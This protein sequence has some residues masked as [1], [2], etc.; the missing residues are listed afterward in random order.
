MLHFKYIKIQTNILN[1]NNSQFYSIFGQINVALMSIRDIF[2]NIKNLNSSKKQLYDLQSVFYRNKLL[3]RPMTSF[4]KSK[5]N[6]LLNI[7]LP[8]LSGRRKK[9]KE[10]W[11]IYIVRFIPK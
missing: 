8:S 7:L 9:V 2:Q 3:K 10:I 5:N 4:V 6:T 11:N 1:S